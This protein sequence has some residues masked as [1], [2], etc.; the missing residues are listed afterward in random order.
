MIISNFHR[1]MRALNQVNSLLGITPTWMSI[2]LKIVTQNVV[3]IVIDSMLE[4]I[5][6]EKTVDIYGHV[7]CLR[8]QSNYMVQTEDQYMGTATVKPYIATQSPTSEAT[9][10]LWRMLWGANSTII[11]MLTKL[12]RK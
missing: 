9:E 11:V 7:T 1:N 5:R 10:D 2:S 8:A 12:K 4:G 6:H 3:F